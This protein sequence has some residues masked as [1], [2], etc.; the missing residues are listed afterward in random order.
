MTPQRIG[1]LCGLWLAIILMMVSG[2]LYVRVGHPMAERTDVFFQSDAGGLIEDAVL[3]RDFRARGTHPLI[4]PLW[5]LP[6]HH[7]AQAGSAVVP[8]RVTAVIMSRLLVAITAGI[9]FGVL[10]STLVRRGLSPLR[11]FVF[12]TLTGVANGHTLAAIPDHFGLSVGLIAICFAIGL[13][14]RPDQS[15]LRCL[16]ILAPVV[17]GIT[18]TNALLPIGLIVLLLVMRNKMHWKR[19]HGLIALIG[20]GIFLAIAGVVIRTPSI[21]NRI[22]E[23]ISLYLNLRLVTD[24]PSAMGYMIRGWTD[25]VVAPTP[26]VLRNNLER[27][28]MLTYERED[29]PRPFWPHEP[30]QS[31]GS[32]VWLGLLIWGTYQAW[33]DAAN[34]WIVF[35]AGGW[36]IGNGLFHNLWGDEYFLYT[37]HYSIALL[38][39]AAMGF[40]TMPGKIFY[41]SIV[42][43]LISA[44]DTLRNYHA[45]LST[46]FE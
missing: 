31:V 1:K 15:K 18:I 11:A 5:T 10:A 37:P 17:L 38:V 6:L 9:G 36:A 35:G 42:V 45:L 39:L 27:L 12:T 24:F 29:G 33:R 26:V 28:P 8:P 41:P 22:Q 34:R 19:R 7:L 43:V 44:L 16:A 21:H 2:V 40:R 32:L 30:L 4:Y 46:I 13:S 3:N 25:A 14:D 23:R 20:I